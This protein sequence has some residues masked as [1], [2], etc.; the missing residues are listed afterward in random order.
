MSITSPRTYKALA[1]AFLFCLSVFLIACGGDAG[2]SSDDG[3]AETSA[4]HTHD[5]G[6]TCYKCDTT[7]RE[8]GRL[9]CAEHE[10]YEDRCWIC[11]PQ[12]EDASRPYCKEHHLYE[13]ECHIC[14]P[15]LLKDDAGAS[16]APSSSGAGALF[17][18]EHNVPEA[19]CGIC[20]PQLAGA[21]KAGQSL[22]I[23]MP[24]ARSAELAGLTLEH[25]VLGDATETL[26]LLGEV[27]Y[28]ENR[29][30]KVTPLASGV[31][32]DIRV[33]VGE[34][35]EAGQVLAVVN[36]SAAAQ[37]KSSYLSALAELEVSTTAYEREQQLAKENIAARRDLQEAAAAHRLAE[38]AS[39]QAH[40]Q[41]LNLG[42][43]EGDV[44]GIEK[45]QSA[46]SDL[47]IRAPFAG[48][49]VDRKAT[50]GEA[51]DSDALFEIADLTTMWI[52]LAVPEDQVYRLAKGCS[53]IAHARSTPQR[54]IKGTVTWISPQID[55]RSRMVRARATVSN[56]TADL[57]HG[58]F[59]E[60]SA[61]LGDKVESLQ[62]PSESVHELDGAMYVFVREQPDLF[63]IRRV[64]IGPRLASGNTAVFAG[65]AEADSVVT[66]GSF[67]MRTEFLKSR[68][69]A[70]CVDD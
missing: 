39:R 48:T 64:E 65:I 37:A 36:S 51:V 68:L 56:P 38:L 42:F 12:I 28:N 14:N 22:S 63:A 49:V 17:C 41:L 62:V 31:L 15:A 18:K 69:G 29:R 46:S 50:L 11:Q 55:E 59:V 23:R 32:S 4:A 27:R 6:S 40:Q 66:G 16:A 5:D 26:N 54:Q 19:E 70:G 45:S 24:S 25:P 13:D 30:A 44:A 60:V 35:V 21:L 1:M 47:P 10:R 61:L 43:S 57:R 34:T 67:T 53:I 9:W 52:E 2:T 20:Q 58:S 3:D 8:A 7:K 33:D